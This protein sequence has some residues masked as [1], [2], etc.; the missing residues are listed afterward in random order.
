MYTSNRLCIHNI[1][2]DTSAYV[3]TVCYIGL[4]LYTV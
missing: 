1:S 2:S 3:H 4:A